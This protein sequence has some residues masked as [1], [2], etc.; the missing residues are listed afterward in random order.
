[1]RGENEP[2]HQNVSSKSLI[3]ARNELSSSLPLH[4]AP[5]AP[6]VWLCQP[7]GRESRQNMQ[8]II[9][10]RT[11]LALGDELSGNFVCGQWKNVVIG[12][13]DLGGGGEDFVHLERRKLYKIYRIGIPSIIV[14]SLLRFYFFGFPFSPI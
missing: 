5:I 13:W 7:P 3:P 4:S 11:F 14:K 1:M 6:I 8:T 10:H 2:L 9:A 12:L